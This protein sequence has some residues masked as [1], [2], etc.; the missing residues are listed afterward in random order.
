VTISGLSRLTAAIGRALGALA[1]ICFRH[2]LL[3]LLLNA[4][5]VAAATWSASRLRLD[6]DITN[7]LPPTYDSVRNVEELRSRFGGVGFVVLMVDGGTPEAR[8]RFADEVAPELSKLERVSFVDEATPVAFFEQRALYF[9]DVADLEV[10]RNGLKQRQTYEIQRSYL[11]LDD[12]QPPTLDFSAIIAKHEG[13]L[14]AL[15]GPA[16]DDRA[17]PSDAPATHYH[18][19]DART[20]LAIF[21]RPTE[22]ASDLDFTR[23]VVAD[24]EGVLERVRP[25]AYDPGM[26][27]RLTGRYKKRVDLQLMMGADLKLTSSLALLLVVAYVGFHFRR[28]F[29]ILLV[30]APLFL[31]ITMSYGVAA[32]LFGKLNILTAS[33]STTG[34]TSSGGTWRGSPPERRPRPRCVRPS[35]K[36]AGCRSLPR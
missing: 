33:A 29:A 13:R 4:G 32:V 22:L 21:V 24:V 9:L 6:P 31:G 14:R 20:K 16:I 2:A 30:L 11:D 18:E 36:R 27:V 23:K 25:D 1:S 10:M 3:A 19:D 5:L 7:L 26:R 34:S 12:A 15:G 8:R 28:F 35:A 17:G